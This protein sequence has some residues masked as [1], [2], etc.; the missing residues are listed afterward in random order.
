MNYYQAEPSKTLSQG[1]T[2][3]MRMSSKDVTK[4]N[5]TSLSNHPKNTSQYNSNYQSINQSMDAVP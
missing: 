4:P 1:T 2:K 3:M 5:D